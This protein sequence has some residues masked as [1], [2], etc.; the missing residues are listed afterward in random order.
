[1]AAAVEGEGATPGVTAVV[2]GTPVVGLT[3]D[4]LLRFLG[5]D[6]IAKVSSRDLGAV[7]A[8]R[9]DGATTVAASL[10]ICRAAGLRVFATGGIGGVHREP[11]FDESADLL[12][13]SR[14]PTIVVC[15]GAKS[16]LDLAATLEHLETLGVAVVGYQTDELPGFLYAN[17]GLRLPTRCD[18]ARAIANVFRAQRQVGHPSALLVV[19]AP[20]A[21][22]ALNRDEAE[23]AIATAIFQARTAGI[24]GAATTPFLLAAVERTTSGRSLS[25]NLSLLESNARLAAEIAVELGVSHD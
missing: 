10:T 19:Q 16:V 9:G 6:G 5:R 4:E 25:V 7:M 17:T 11:P 15:A 20:P 3:P 18:S 21:A 1:M 12:E 8:G 13:L 23:E 24:R 14:T 22:T 2:G